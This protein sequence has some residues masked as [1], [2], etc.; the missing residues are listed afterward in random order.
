MCLS[1][2]AYAVE[3]PLTDE[4]QILGLE[5]AWA[6][7]VEMH[8]RAALERILASEF[9]FIAPDGRLMTRAAYIAEK[10]SGSADIHS[11]E[12]SEMLVRVFGSTALVSGLSTIDESIAGKRCQYQI[13]W[14]DVWIKRDGAWQVLSGQATP[15][16][17]GWNSVLIVRES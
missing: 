13:R 4:R 14:K 16:N 6:R 8:D 9:N 17:A 15:V 5:E 12:L 7:A 10:A 3:S 2:L 1:E 11:F